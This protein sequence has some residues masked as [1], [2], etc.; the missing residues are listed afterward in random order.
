MDSPSVSFSI[1]LSVF[2]LSLSFCSLFLSL[3]SFSLSLCLSLFLSSLS[4]SL[5][6]CFCLSLS[7]A[8]LSSKFLQP[9]LL[10]GDVYC[11][12]SL[13]PLS[14]GL[15]SGFESPDLDRPGRLPPQ[16]SLLGNCLRLR[17]I[18][19]VKKKS[20][21]YF[22]S[23]VSD[24]GG[25]LSYWATWRPRPLGTCVSCRHCRSSI[26]SSCGTTTRKTRCRTRWGPF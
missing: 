16:Q 17:T 23:V 24:W 25:C 4:L 15:V 6:L 26:R 21:P 1:F 3:L 8:S 5:S 9:K 7:G 10:G 20:T 14:L 2:S 13:R 12:Y 11:H 22:R 19:F 18:F